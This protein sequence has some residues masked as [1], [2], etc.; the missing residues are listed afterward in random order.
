MAKTIILIDGQNLYY[1]L[2]NIKL[3]EN[4]IDWDKFFNLI[5]NTNDTIIRAYWFRPGK[6]LDTHYNRKNITKAVIGRDPRFKQY[7]G[8]FWNKGVINSVIKTQVKK[9]VDDIESW[10]N[11]EKVRFDS[12]QRAYDFLPQKYPKIKMVKVGILKINPYEQKMVGEKGVDVALAV[13]MVKHSAENDCEKIILISGDYDYSE[14]INYSQ[15]KMKQVHIVKI[16]KG[17][18]PKNK[19]VSVELS[20]LADEVINVYES[21]IMSKCLVKE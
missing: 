13:R 11:K 12:I 6:I 7:A 18:P 2:K 17:V 14:A 16:Y 4:D 15:E 1:S 20:A 3:V 9:T 19:N 8:Q 10:I 5:V 21:D